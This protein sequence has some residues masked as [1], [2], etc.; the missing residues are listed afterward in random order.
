MSLIEIA[1][2]IFGRFLADSYSKVGRIFPCQTWVMFLTAAVSSLVSLFGKLS[3]SIT[4]PPLLPPPAPGKS[5]PLTL[6]LG[7]TLGGTFL[8]IVPPEDAP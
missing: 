5:T 6:G 7:G 2:A 1:E 3:M 8:P 4:S